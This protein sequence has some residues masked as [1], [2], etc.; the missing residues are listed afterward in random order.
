VTLKSRSV[1]RTDQV[2]L[3]WIDTAALGWIAS[4]IIHSADKGTDHRTSTCRLRPSLR[5]V[6][7]H[8]LA[9]YTVASGHWRSNALIVR[10]RRPVRGQVR[11]TAASG[12]RGSETRDWIRTVAVGDT[13]ASFGWMRVAIR[14]GQGHFDERS[15]QPNKEATRDAEPRKAVIATEYR[16][17][18]SPSRRTQLT[19]ASWPRSH[20]VTIQ[21]FCGY[22]GNAIA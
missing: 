9:G 13:S 8:R 12:S 6:A 18:S 20:N 15:Q 3:L 11:C 19:N 2:G 10:Q 5:L 1:F 16:H 4:A 22:K 7:V 17:D 14:K 21:S